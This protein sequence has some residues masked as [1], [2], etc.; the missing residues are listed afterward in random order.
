VIGEPAFASN[1]IGLPFPHIEW[2]IVP[3]DGEADFGRLAVRGPSVMR[4]Y[5]DAT[6]GYWGLDDEGFFAT[7]DLVAHT[8]EGLRLLGRYHRCFKTGGKFVNP[9]IVESLLMR[10]DDVRNAVCSPKPHDILGQ[11]SLVKVVFEKS[12]EIDVCYVRSAHGNW[13]PTWCQRRLLPCG[14]CLGVV[15]AKR[16]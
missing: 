2:K 11:V 12:A 6:R 3:V 14:T 5:V 16:C 9:A 1:E 10:Q 15:A 4:G 8:P 7:N 13:S